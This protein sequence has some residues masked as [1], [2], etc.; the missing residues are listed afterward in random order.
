MQNEVSEEL[1][2]Y[3]QIGG[4]GDRQARARAGEPKNIHKIRSKPLAII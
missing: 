3:D 1:D 2:E 4:E